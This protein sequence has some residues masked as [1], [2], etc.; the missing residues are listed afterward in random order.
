MSIKG[1]NIDRSWSLFLDRDGVINKRI[2]GG[3]VKDVEEFEF[4][5]DVPEA[6]SGLS[7]LFGNVFVVTNQ[8]G[9]GKGIMTERNL[10]EIHHY[11][12]E[13]IGNSG[14]R[15][16]K[17]YFASNLRGAEQDRR[18]PAPSMALEAK[19]DY[20]DIDFSRAV[21]IGDTDSDILFGKNLGMKTVRVLSE[22]RIG[23]TADLEVNGLM[24]F[25]NLVNT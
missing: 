19:R 9:I 11:M 3:Y 15:I 10:S 16:A 24:E 22:E 25:Y 18:K 5:P 20:P 7:S 4:L 17:I 13:A 14:G 12:V 21:M 23:E 2:F 6:I 1:W 8:Q